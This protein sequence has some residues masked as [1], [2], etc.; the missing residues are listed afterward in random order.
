LLAL[1]GDAASKLAALLVVVI[2]ARTLSIDEFSVFITGLAAAGVLVATLDLGSGLVLTRDG[3][4][5][6]AS[7]RA[8]YRGLII[9]RIP[10]AVVVLIVAL[11]TGF[12]VGQPL[13]ALAVAALAVSGAF[14][15]TVLGL[16]RSRQDIRPEAIQKGVAAVLFVAAALASRTVPR[17]DVLLGAFALITVATIAPLARRAT[18]LAT[19]DERTS[20][21][22]GAA[23]RRAAPVGLLTLATVAYYR[24]GVLALAALTDSKETA[25]FGV[26]SSIAFGMLMLPNAVTSALLPRLS[27][28]DDPVR[29]IE[30]ARRALLWTFLVAL[31]LAA[32]AAVVVPL[33]LPRVLGSQYETAGIPFAVLCLGVPLIAMSGVIGTLLLSTRRLRPLGVQVAASLVVNLAALALLAPLLGATGAALATV[34]CEGT[35]FVLLARAARY[36]LP[37]LIARQPLPRLSA[38]ESTIAATR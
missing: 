12:V 2:A 14:A 15:L 23:L 37:G 1:S 17:A 8:L 4:T 31:V 36:S 16:Y 32:A 6:G 26:A 9:G 18:A 35:G 13:A 5:D 21:S 7:A 22:A 19:L 38:A 24:S 28:D 3:A 29:R 34:L 20:S 30:Y 33:A 25:A 11:I 10:L 27:A